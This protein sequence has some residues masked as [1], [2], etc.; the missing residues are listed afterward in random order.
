[1]AATKAKPKRD[2]DCLIIFGPEA[3]RA[4]QDLAKQLD[5]PVTTVVE[6]ALGLFRYAIA[7]QRD[8]G[9]LIAI[10]QDADMELRI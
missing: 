8:G 7:L 6:R 5:V 9:K 3:L 1:M 4:V 10:T 2:P